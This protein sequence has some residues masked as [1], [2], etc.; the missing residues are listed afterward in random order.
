MIFHIILVLSMSTLALVS[1]RNVFL[2][3]FSGIFQQSGS[4]FRGFALSWSI[5]FA[6]NRVFRKNAWV[7]QSCVKTGD[8]TA[9]VVKG[10]GLFHVVGH[11]VCGITFCFIISFFKSFHIDDHTVDRLLDELEHFGVKAENFTHGMRLWETKRT[12]EV[13]HD[14]RVGLK[15]WPVKCLFHLC[16]NL[17]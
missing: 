5:E 3:E 16:F 8:Q 12:H 11:G 6:H 4:F 14:F 13:G 1:W 7:I 2:L 10:T 17:L 9:S 15:R